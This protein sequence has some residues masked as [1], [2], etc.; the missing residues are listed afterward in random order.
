[1]P[2]RTDA[3][4]AALRSLAGRVEFP[5][6]PPIAP[7]VGARLRADAARAHRPPFAAA[8]LWSR[9]RLIAAIAIGMLLLAGA[10]VAARLSIGA[11]RI[12]VVPSL[13]PSAAPEAPAAFGKEIS[14]RDAVEA[15][16]VEP[17]WPRALDEPDDVYA[18][19]PGTGSAALV[20]AWRPANGLP[21][22]PR[23]P[24]SAVLFELRGDL[25]IATKIVL[26]PDIRPARVDGERA[27]WISGAHDLSLQG[28]FGGAVI[29]VVGNVLLWEDD[30]GVTYRL[31]TMLPRA[32]AISLAETLG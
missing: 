27:F 31:E 3:L 9:R 22:I 20:L 26:S 10:A 24:W 2:E 16:G 32:E 8:A 12:G 7:T 28:A 13:A 14:L 6:V 5:D 30:A 19:R 25:D 29:R 17:R 18:V 4:D 21:T 11:V 23:T 1:M 15:T